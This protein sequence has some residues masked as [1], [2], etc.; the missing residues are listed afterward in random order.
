LRAAAN[1]WRTADAGQASE[2][3]VEGRISPDLIVVAQSYPG[4]FS[5]PRIARLRQLAPVARVL[6]V[7]GSWCEGEMRSGAPWPASARVYWHQ[8]PARGRRELA[9]F[10]RGRSCAWALPPT[11]TEEERVL[12]DFPAPACGRGAGGEGGLVAIH[13]SSFETWDWLAAAC[14]SRGYATVWQR[15]SRGVCVEGAAWGIFDAA[16]LGPRE[17]VGLQQLVARLRPAPVVALISFPRVE[18]R[19]RA[20]AVGAAAVLSKPLAVEDLFGE[21]EAATVPGPWPSPFAPRK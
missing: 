16:E 21:A 8:W 9:Q 18:D 19:E 11:A 12:A 13:T 7:M 17:E 1:V 2:A 5:E 20:L 14:R 4:Q 3:L 6:G 10:A 15:D